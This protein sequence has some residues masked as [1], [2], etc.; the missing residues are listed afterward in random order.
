MHVGAARRRA[1]VR[2]S[3]EERREFLDEDGAL[4]VRRPA[5]F[6]RAVAPREARRRARDARDRLGPHAIDARSRVGV[7]SRTPQLF[8]TRV[9]CVGCHCVL[10]KTPSGA[11][12]PLPYDW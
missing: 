1:G 7:E 12:P 6:V 10:E 9:G 3:G 8:D 5:E 2:G 4:G 11:Y